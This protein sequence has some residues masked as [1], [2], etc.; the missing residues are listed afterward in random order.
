MTNIIIAF[1]A[2]FLIVGAVFALSIKNLDYLLD[3]KNKTIEVN[4]KIIYLDKRLIGGS[5]IYDLTIRY[6]DMEGDKHTIEISS[7]DP[8]LWNYKEGDNIKVRYLNSS[9]KQV[10][11]SL[12][13]GQIEKSY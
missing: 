4:A 10:Y 8:E 2:V 13:F 9:P 3:L 7:L 12:D 1:C 6:T 11:L 5:P